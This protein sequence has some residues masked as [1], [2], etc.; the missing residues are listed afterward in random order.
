MLTGLKAWRRR[1]IIDYSGGRGLQDNGEHRQAWPWFLRA[2]M[3][4]P[5]IPKFYA[6]LLLNALRRRVG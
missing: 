2:I 6:A 3:H 4:W 1:A 5:F